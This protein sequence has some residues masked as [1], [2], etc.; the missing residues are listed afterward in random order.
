MLQLMVIKLLSR[1][2]AHT[3]LLLILARRNAV[4]VD[5]IAV[6]VFDGL[7]DVGGVFGFVAVAGLRD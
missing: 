7:G 6:A 2:L 3:Q 4:L 5:C 1:K